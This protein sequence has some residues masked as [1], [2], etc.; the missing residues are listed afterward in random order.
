[1]NQA[2]GPAV[3]VGKIDGSAVRHVNPERQSRT[4]HDKRIRTAMKSRTV[5]HDHFPAV[6]LLRRGDHG[7]VKTMAA[8]KVL[9]GGSQPGQGGGTIRLDIHPRD[10]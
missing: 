1:M 3:L 10:A 8:Q 7:R 2:N 5:G 4:V 9:L 6:D